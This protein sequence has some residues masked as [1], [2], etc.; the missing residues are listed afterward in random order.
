MGPP[1]GDTSLD[2]DDNDVS[3]PPSPLRETSGCCGGGL[4]MT[5]NGP[6]HNLAL[7]LT[8]TLA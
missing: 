1:R 5:A 4:R 8:L 2:A 6:S 3:L 7:T